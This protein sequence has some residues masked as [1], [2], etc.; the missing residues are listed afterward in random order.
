[1]KIAVIG[2][3]HIGAR[4]DSLVFADH[5]ITWFEKLLK[6]LVKEKIDHVIQVGDVFD[7]RKFINFQILNL[8]K[9]LVFDQFKKHNITLDIIVGNHDIAHK[10]HSEVNSPILL[11]KEYDNVKV[12]LNPTEVMLGNTKVLYVPWI[13]AANEAAT[14]SAVKNTTATIAFGHFEFRGFQMDKGHLMEEGMDSKLFKKFDTVYSGHYHHKSDDGHVFYLGTPYQ[15]TW[16]DFGSTKG[17][18]LW[19]S[20]SLQLEFKP[21][22]PDTEI[23]QHITYNECVELP[24]SYWRDFDCSSYTNK[25]VKV[26]VVNKQNLYVFDQFWDRLI[27]S[28]P[29]D[30]KIIEDMID[31]DSV[32]DAD[33][34]LDDTEKV[35]DT[36][37]DAVD[38]Q[39]D[40]P[41][42][43]TILK[44]LYVEALHVEDV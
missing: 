18:H 5:H 21:N 39:L 44:Q 41:K 42:L 11:L 34:N 28:S 15:M 24:E 38:T 29:A 6:Y 30:V 9:G 35:L 20:D 2:D 23:F 16:V 36:F 32:A 31:V 37:V 14:M 10:N 33:L 25:M 1:M 8:W 4:N 40:K 13:N 3:M 17:F 12:Y 7:R 19:D 22:T 26:F 27:E 43:K